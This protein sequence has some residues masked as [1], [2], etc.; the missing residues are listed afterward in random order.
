MASSEKSTATPEVAPLTV[1]DIPH[2]NASGNPRVDETDIRAILTTAPGRSF[3]VPQTGEF[4]LV[5]PWRSRYDLPCVHTLWSFEHDGTLIEAAAG[6]SADAGAAAL[7]MLETGERR[8]P[9]F[10]SHN[11]FE[12]IEIIRTYEHGE[13]QVLGRQHDP[14]AQRFVRVGL[15]NPMLIDAIERI[16]H[17][18]FPWFWW[19]SAAE[20][21][22][23]LR[24]P[25]VEVWAGVRA[26]DDVV[27]YV[28]FTG[29]NTWAHL[30]RI[31]V[32]PAMQGRG[33]G[34]SAVA[35]AAQRM[36]ANG[37]HRI[38]LSTQ[39]SNRGS[40]TLYES[41]GFHHTRESDYDVYGIVL[42][43]GRVYRAADPSSSPHESW[44]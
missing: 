21:D 10:Y 41:L 8:R 6:A 17:A 13:P 15:D 38:G 44:D 34:R 24:F 16:D 7:V 18:A 30:D 35:F 14:S 33:L 42:D 4:V 39:S 11:G 20:F 26:N 31:A 28:G 23:Y 29:Y 40:R 5:T 25:G 2:L 32:T 27:S 36:A 19:N 37:A 3:W 12:R 9:G 22:A 1:A 43:A